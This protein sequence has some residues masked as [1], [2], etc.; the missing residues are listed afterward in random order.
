MEIECKIYHCD[1]NLYVCLDRDK[2]FINQ[3]YGIAYSESQERGLV[4]FGDINARIHC[5]MAHNIYTCIGK[6]PWMKRG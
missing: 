2:P 1:F 5:N 3:A 6:L 4:V